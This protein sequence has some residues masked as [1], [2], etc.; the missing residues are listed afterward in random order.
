MERVIVAKNT[1]VYK[2]KEGYYWVANKCLVDTGICSFLII[3][4]VYCE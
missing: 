4:S 3:L 2:M 1:Y